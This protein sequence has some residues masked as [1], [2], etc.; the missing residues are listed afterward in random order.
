MRKLS[1]DGQDTAFLSLW[2]LLMKS[3]QTGSPGRSVVP[4]REPTLLRQNLPG[5]QHGLGKFRGKDGKAGSYWLLGSLQIWKIPWPHGSEA[6]ILLVGGLEP[7]LFSHY[8]GNNHPNWL[9]FSEELKPPANQSS[10]PGKLLSTI[11]GRFPLCFFSTSGK[12]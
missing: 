11:C 12:A 5:R 9:I 7:F 2:C 3:R 1:R 8:I 4:H 6:H 10:F